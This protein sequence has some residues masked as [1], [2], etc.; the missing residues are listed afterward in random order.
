MST[1][2]KYYCLKDDITISL[3]QTNPKILG[4]DII[5]QKNLRYPGIEKDNESVEL[6]IHE[7]S[8]IIKLVVSKAD[9]IEIN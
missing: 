9:I 4:A 2:I 1:T 7:H 5:I 8:S 3:N 6:Y